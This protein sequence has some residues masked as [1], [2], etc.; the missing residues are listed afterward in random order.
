MYSNSDPV[1]AEMPVILFKE[2][3]TAVSFLRVFVGRINMYSAGY[4]ASL[5]TDSMPTLIIGDCYSDMCSWVP[6][7]PM[8]RTAE[9]C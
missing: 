4:L 3:T 1:K 2:I 5:A 9:Q 7:T 6:F 8:V